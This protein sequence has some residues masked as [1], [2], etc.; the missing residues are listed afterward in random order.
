MR[1]YYRQTKIVA[2]V[3]PATE[4]REKLAQL[5]TAGVD[6]IRLNMA[7]GSGEWVTSLMQRIRE[8]SEEVGR[9][10]A[11]KLLTGGG[12]AIPESARHILAQEARSSSALNHPNICMIFGLEDFDGRPGIVMEFLTG[13]TLAA[14]IRALPQFRETKMILISSAGEN[15]HSEAAKKN[16]DAVL[17]KPFVMKELL[18]CL[19]K[20]LPQ[21]EK[22]SPAE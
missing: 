8:V 18:T 2:T 20:V 3:G 12:G 19:N 13:E 9:H 14:R 21:P 16:L 22:T 1:G 4:S 10:V 5:I 15:G 17:L 11:V 6:V 7:H